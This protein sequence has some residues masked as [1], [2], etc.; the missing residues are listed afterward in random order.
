MAEKPGS[1]R[2]RAELDSHAR[3]S[4]NVICDP[5]VYFRVNLRQY[6]GTCR[7]GIRLEIL[8]SIL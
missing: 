1:K 6:E 4:K 3:R 5:N 7:Y 2:A 8:K